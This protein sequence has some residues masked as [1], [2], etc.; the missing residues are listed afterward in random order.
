M[1]RHHFDVAKVEAS[2]IAG[3]LSVLAGWP[4]TAA[5]AYRLQ[6]GRSIIIE[7]KSREKNR[8][9]NPISGLGSMFTGLRRRLRTADCELLVANG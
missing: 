9:G 1:A 2:T 6:R 8:P 7:A 3:R 4:K 5:I